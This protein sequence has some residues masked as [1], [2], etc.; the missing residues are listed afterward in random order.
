MSGSRGAK[1]LK[2][3]ILSQDLMGKPRYTLSFGDAHE[4]LTE[5]EEEAGRGREAVRELTALKIDLG[6]TDE[7]PLHYRGDGKVPCQRAMLSMSR[8]WAAADTVPPFISMFWVMTA[9]KYL[10]RFPFKE[11][12]RKNLAKALDCV[13]KAHDALGGSKDD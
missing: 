7:T 9:F 11:G 8:G 4:L 12:P 1:R 5:V 2:E 10:W 13:Q 6:W 3:S